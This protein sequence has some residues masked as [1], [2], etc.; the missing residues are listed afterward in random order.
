M[1]EA[2]F[3]RA[4]HGVNPHDFVH[5]WFILFDGKAS[6]SDQ[7]LNQLGSSGLALNQERFGAER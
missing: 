3:N 2:V 1:N 6:L 7:F 5:G 4:G